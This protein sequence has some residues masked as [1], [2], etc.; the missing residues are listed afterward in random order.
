[1]ILQESGAVEALLDSLPSCVLPSRKPHRVL[2]DR[3]QLIC[4]YDESQLTWSTFHPTVEFGVS[5]NVD[6]IYGITIF[7]VQ[8]EW[9]NTKTHYLHFLQQKPTLQRMSLNLRAKKLNLEVYWFLKRR[10]AL[11]TNRNSTSQT[12][13]TND[14]NLINSFKILKICS[15]IWTSWGTVCLL[16]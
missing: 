9:R 2:P 5:T 4:K 1:M 15:R 11:T 7:R 8:L 16:R 12:L 10:H 13:I 14:T 6:L 3:A